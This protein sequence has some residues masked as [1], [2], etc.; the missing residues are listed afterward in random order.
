MVM[1]PWSVCTRPNSFTAVEGGFVVAKDPLVAEK[2]EW[3]RRFGH[4]GPEEFHGVGINAK[5]SELHAAMGLCNLK[6]VEEISEKRK[7]ACDLYEQALFNKGNSGLLPYVYRN[8]VS[9][10][11]AYYPLIFDSEA[12]LLQVLVS[13]KEANIFP[14]RYFHPDL[15]SCFTDDHQYCPLSM[16]ISR[17]ILC[18]PLAEST[19]KAKINRVI[20]VINQS[21]SS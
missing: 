4:K 13:L 9:Q 8:E 21:L 17:R 16:D 6:H 20:S 10:N 15:S 3:M 14:R 11:Y 19:D 5:M 1:R 18:L 12:L 2:V 7:V